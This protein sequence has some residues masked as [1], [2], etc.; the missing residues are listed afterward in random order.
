MTTTLMIIIALVLTGLVVLAVTTFNRI[1][2]LGNEITQAWSNIAVELTRRVDILDSM[3]DAVQ[4]YTEHEHDTFRGVAEARNAVRAAA[5]PSQA[6]AATTA[7]N[8]AAGTIYGVVERYPKLKASKQFTQLNQQHIDN[9]DRVGA[10]RRYFNQVVVTYNTTIS[11]LPVVLLAGVLGIAKREYFEDER[12]DP[13]GPRYNMA[14][15][16]AADPPPSFRAD[17]SA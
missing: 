5:T 7:L 6:V 17:A 10:A 16:N 12:S 4:R 8:Q 14:R 2:R 3:V 9:A 11:T 13:H 1:A 15:R